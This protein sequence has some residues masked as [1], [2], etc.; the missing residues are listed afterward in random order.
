MK[1]NAQLIEE[2]NDALTDLAWGSV[3]IYV[4]DNIV[5][6]ITVKNIKRPE[7]LQKVAKV[8]QKI[9]RINLRY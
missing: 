7:F 5:T 3:E 1:K 6:Q 2:I 9:L 8:L 4:Q